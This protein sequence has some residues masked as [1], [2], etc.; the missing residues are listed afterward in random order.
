MRQE[1]K[2]AGVYQGLNHETLGRVTSRR[3]TLAWL[4]HNGFSLGADLHFPGG[5]KLVDTLNRTN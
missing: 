2:H 1:D 4:L 3:R 5:V